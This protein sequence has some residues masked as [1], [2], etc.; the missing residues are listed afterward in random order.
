MIYG[1]VIVLYAKQ[2][3]YGMEHADIRSAEDAIRAA[4]S[5]E[6]IFFML[7]SFGLK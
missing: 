4:K 3:L 5:A 7:Y 2:F 1:F 6:R